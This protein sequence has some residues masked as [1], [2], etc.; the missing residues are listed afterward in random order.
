MFAF[1]NA[2]YLPYGK[3]DIIL[4]AKLRYDINSCSRRD[5]DISHCEAIYRTKYIAN[6][7]GIYIAAECP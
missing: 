5:S 2:I 1:T 6:S 4:Q 7:E 3:F